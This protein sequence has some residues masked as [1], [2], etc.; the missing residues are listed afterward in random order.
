MYNKKYFIVR[1]TIVLGRNWKSFIL[2]TV[3]NLG[4]NN[5]YQRSRK[6][7]SLWHV[8]WVYHEQ[9]CIGAPRW[10]LVHCAFAWMLLEVRKTVSENYGSIFTFSYDLHIPRLRVTELTLPLPLPLPSRASITSQSRAHMDNYTFSVVG[11]SKGEWSV[12]IIRKYNNSKKECAQAYL[13]S[14]QYLCLGP[15][16]ASI[17]KSSISV[18]R[19][20]TEV[21]YFNLD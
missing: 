8:G 16:S 9:C 12:V 13:V 7:T 18:A 10:N 15:T 19:Y 6:D 14:C 20:F 4:L 17:S 21:F 1:V 11:V 2:I 3:L 5:F